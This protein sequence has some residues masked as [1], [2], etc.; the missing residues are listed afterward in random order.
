MKRKKKRK[1]TK[2]F[3]ILMLSLTLFAV[4]SFFNMKGDEEYLASAYTKK[5]KNSSS[6]IIDN[7]KAVDQHPEYPTG[8]ESVSLYI[9]LKH[10]NVDVTIDKIINKLPK[11]E[12][13]YEIN[14]ELYGA[15]PEKEFVGSPYN[16][17]SYGVFEEPIKKAAN[18]FKSGA[19]SARDFSI[20]KLKNL[21][22]SGKPAIVW[23][24]IYEDLSDLEYT[25]TWT[26]ETD[27]LE[28]LWPRGEHAVVLYG[29]DEDFY[30]I[31]NPY[32]GEKYP[33]EKEIF[34]YNYEIMGSRV[35]YYND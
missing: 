30:Y 20:K 31:S 33:L 28:I 13:P 32:N 8:C 9:L 29:F 14:G 16:D 4:F 26:S 6:Y 1:F 19:V 23:T 27:G 15:D 17:Y 5:S 35:V 34:E 18:K 7:I 24:R 21:I 10:Y 12:V 22:K 3:K 25:D 2:S 11:G